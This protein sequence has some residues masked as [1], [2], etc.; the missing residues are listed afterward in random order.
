LSQALAVKLKSLII[1]LFLSYQNF[2]CSN[3]TSPLENLLNSH[4]LD[5]SSSSFSLINEKILSAAAVATC[6]L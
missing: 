2:T 3:T 6:N 4:F 1:V 5:S